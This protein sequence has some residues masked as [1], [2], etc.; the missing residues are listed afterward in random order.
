[1]PR[2]SGVYGWSYE[3]GQLSAAGPI[4]RANEQEFVQIFRGQR[5]FSITAPSWEEGKRRALRSV[6]ERGGLPV[7]EGSEQEQEVSNE[8]GSGRQS[9]RQT[10]GR[11]EGLSTFQEIRE[12]FKQRRE[13]D[14]PVEQPTRV[15]QSPWDYD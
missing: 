7:P 12:A 4:T 8:F 15:R 3:S 1:M 5:S 13:S 9:D 14:Q 2:Y 11:Q 6:G 10:D